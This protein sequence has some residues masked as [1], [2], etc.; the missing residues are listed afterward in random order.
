MA[1][2]RKNL[3]DF[4]TEMFEN[5]IFGQIRYVRPDPEFDPW[6]VAADVCKVLGLSNTTMAVKQLDDDEKM[7][8]ILIDN[9]SKNGVTNTL[10]SNEGSSNAISRGWIEL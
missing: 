8:V 7:T 5:E 6:F 4:A 1:M 3:P 2:K 10:S 9:R